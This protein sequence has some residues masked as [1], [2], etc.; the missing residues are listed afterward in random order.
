MKMTL[1]DGRTMSVWV[2]RAGAEIV[3]RG[4][5]EVPGWNKATFTIAHFMPNGV[6][7]ICRNIPKEIPFAR[8]IIPGKG[9]AEWFDKSDGLEITEEKS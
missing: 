4:R 1:D 2:D 3:L 5:L 8:V 6:M 7:R 9:I